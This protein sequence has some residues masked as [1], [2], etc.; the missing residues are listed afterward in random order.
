HAG[1]MRAC[2]NSHTLFLFGEPHQGHRRIFF[3]H[4]NQMHQPG[5]RQRRNQRD[6]A[7]L[8]C[9]VNHARTGLR[10]RHRRGS[11][12]G[13]A[14]YGKLTLISKRRPIRNGDFMRST[15]VTLLLISPLLR[16]QTAKQKP[17]FA[18]ASIKLDPKADGADSEPGPGLLRAQMTLS[19]FVAMAYAVKP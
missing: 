18:A 16:A 5:L 8:E 9:V 4:A 17:T 14:A 15:I 2:R 19:R 11:L 12:S 10:D 3:C 13:F 6:A 7:L 1:E